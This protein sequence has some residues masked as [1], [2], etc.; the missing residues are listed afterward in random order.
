MRAAWAAF[1]KDPVNGL[2][3]YGSPTYNTSEDSLIRLAY[4]NI[5]GP[6]IINPYAYDADYLCQ[7][8][9]CEYYLGSYTAGPGSDCYADRARGLDFGDCLR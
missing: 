1:A 9:G 7:C 3:N 6:N 5:T 8:Y 4:D 2:T